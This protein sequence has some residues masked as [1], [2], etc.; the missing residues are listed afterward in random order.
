MLRHTNMLLVSMPTLCPRRP[1]HATGSRNNS[2]LCVSVYLTPVL[3]D[4]RTICVHK[5]ILSQINP[6]MSHSSSA[7]LLPQSYPWTWHLASKMTVII[8][9]Y[10]PI[11]FLH[12]FYPM[13]SCFCEVYT[14]PHFPWWNPVKE[15][16][17]LVWYLSQNGIPD[18]EHSVVHKDF[19]LES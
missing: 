15:L 5:A 19:I 9:F 14:T 13:I 3:L 18:Y 10:T 4:D 12:N 7:Y 6:S 1:P 11:Y 17:S 16:I 8:W 2:G